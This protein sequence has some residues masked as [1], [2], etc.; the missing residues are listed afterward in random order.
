MQNCLYRLSVVKYALKYWIKW[1]GTYTASL[2]R[3]GT[4][5]KHITQDYISNYLIGTCWRKGFSKHFFEKQ[6][7]QLLQI[8]HTR[9]Q[10]FHIECFF[11]LLSCLLLIYFSY[12]L[13]QIWNLGIE[14][15]L[16]NDFSFT[17]LSLYPTS[18][19]LFVICNLSVNHVKMKWG[20]H[21]LK[22]CCWSL[23]SANTLQTSI[24][25]VI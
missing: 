22:N 11:Y 25:W 8:F 3:S 7:W 24:W 19:Q 10:N 17:D 13:F 4:F 18:C 2:V 14:L 6:V 21:S 5:S 12:L 9:L 1:G 16:R 15:D 20:K 23:N